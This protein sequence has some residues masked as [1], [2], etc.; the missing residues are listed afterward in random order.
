[1]K[2]I[3]PP[4]GSKPIRLIRAWKEKIYGSD[5]GIQPIVQLTGFGMCRTNKTI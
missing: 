3:F 2:K 4:T 5:K 1:M